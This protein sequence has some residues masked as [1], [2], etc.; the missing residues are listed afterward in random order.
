MN[1]PVIRDE[2]FL[3]E[4]IPD[5]GNKYFAGNGYLG[6]RGTLEE[7]GKEQMAAVNLSGVYD[8]H[9]DAWREP[10]NAPN[11]FFVRAQIGETPCFLPDLSPESH[12]QEL[13]T[14]CGLQKRETEWRTPSGVLRLRSERFCS[15]ENLHLLCLRCSVQTDRDAEVRLTVGIDADVWDINGPHYASVECGRDGELLRVL[16]ISGECGHR[17]AVAQ[18]I[19]RDFEAE[20]SFEETPLGIFRRLAFSTRAGTEYS[21][22]VFCAVFTSQDGGAPETRASAAAASA[23]EKGY[24]AALAAHLERWTR[25][26]EQARVTI[27]G[28]GEAQ[29]A[30]DYSVYHLLSLAPRH[31]DSRSIPA[32]GLS[33]QTYK[34]AVFWDTELFLFDFFLANEPRVAKTLLRYRIDTLGGALEKAKQY[35]CEGAFYAWESQEG[36]FDACSDY[37]VTDVF[38]G[39]PVRTWFRDKQVHISAAVV[40]ALMKYIRVTGDEAVL[41]QGGARVTVECARFYRSLLVRKADG[42][43][44]ELRDVLG[45]DEYHERVDNNA[46]TNRTAKFVFDSAAQILRELPEK[47]PQTYAELDRLYP[48]DGELR[49][50]EDASRHL[51]IPQPDPETGVIEQFDGYFTLEDTTPAVLRKRLLDPR[52]YWGGA[53]GVAAHTQV[54]KQADVAALLSLFSQEYSADVLKA[55]WEYYEPRTEHGSSLSACMYALLACRFGEPDRALP[56]FL[57]SA[58]ADLVGGGKQWAGS[59]YI[60]GTHPAA[61]GGAWMT[62]VEGFGGLREENGRP[63]CRSCLPKGWKHLRFRAYCRGRLYSF[64]LTPERALILPLDP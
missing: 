2:G 36:G 4:R 61:A 54:V 48:L 45:P 33:G 29:T 40:L 7:Y 30:L 46:Y 19:V 43:D 44:Y 24:G 23:A 8:R 52:E 13:E 51:R 22:S 18:A 17:V 6:V 11:P 35:G 50:F 62:A 34:G 26:W 28:D 15:M 32:R 60:G 3:P 39:R 56:F 58:A 27:D 5:F 38:T 21:V 14:A 1:L 64:D 59:V 57:K 55:N 63:A 41:E 20:E 53:N 49:K 9:G 16:A 31:V 37:N 42:T 47:F 10:L 25:L 12:A